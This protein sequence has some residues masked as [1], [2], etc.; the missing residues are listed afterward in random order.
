MVRAFSLPM[1]YAGN[2]LLEIKLKQ[3]GD[4]PSVAFSI[5]AFI[6]IIMLSDDDDDD[7]VISGSMQLFFILPVGNEIHYI[8]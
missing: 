4:S 5:F 8:S 1:L 3:L 2:T 6:I 7:D